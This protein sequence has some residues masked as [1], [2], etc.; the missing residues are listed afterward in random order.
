MVVFMLLGRW[1]WSFV[2]ETEGDCG[3]WAGHV[4]AEQWEFEGCAKWLSSLNHRCS[5]CE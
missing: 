5:L 3:H 2:S 1:S 4:F